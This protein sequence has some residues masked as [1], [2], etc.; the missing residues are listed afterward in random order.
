MCLPAMTDIQPSFYGFTDDLGRLRPGAIV[1]DQQ[2][3]RAAR[4][5]FHATEHRRQGV[6]PFIGGHQQAYLHTFMLSPEAP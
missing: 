6:W 3:V 4:L 2:F 5:P 1:P